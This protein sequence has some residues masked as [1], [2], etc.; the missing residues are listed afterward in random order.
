MV[1][2][3]PVFGCFHGAVEMRCGIHLGVE[4]SEAS[5]ISC[6]NTIYPRVGVLTR[7]SCKS[8]KLWRLEK[9]LSD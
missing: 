3:N 4:F 6:T 1:L 9:L 7:S 5:Y 2:W 8:G